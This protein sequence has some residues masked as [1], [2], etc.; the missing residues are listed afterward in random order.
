MQYK[1]ISVPLNHGEEQEEDLNLFLRTH[2][3]LE[4]EKRFVENGVLQWSFCIGYTSGK[5]RDITSH[6]K[7]DYQQELS[8]EDFLRF[9]KLRAI[10]KKVADQLQIPVYAVF[11]NKE[12]SELA[13]IQNLTKESLLQLDGFGKGR[14][15]KTGT[16]FLKLF[17]EKDVEASV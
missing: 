5:P 14:M 9:E 13:S 15:E 12:L 8:T 16:L 7:V 10:R 17:D 3:V 2:K 11:T 6:A 1:I 4:I